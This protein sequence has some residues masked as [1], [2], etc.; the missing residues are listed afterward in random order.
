MLMNTKVSKEAPSNRYK[1][2][3]EGASLLY[4]F[5]YPIDMFHNMLYYIIVERY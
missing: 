3:E 5:V 2:I 4:F 1:V